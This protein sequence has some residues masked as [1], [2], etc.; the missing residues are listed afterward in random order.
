MFSS[1]QK[2]EVKMFSIL[3]LEGT[4]GTLGNELG[5]ISKKEQDISNLNL[6]RCWNAD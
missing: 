3:L 4:Q 6:A 1:P 5:A 2:L